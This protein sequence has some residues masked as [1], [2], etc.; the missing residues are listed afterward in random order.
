V[1]KIYQSLC[2]KFVIWIFF[3]F[4]T[5]DE[6]NVEHKTIF[7]TQKFTCTCEISYGRGCNL[8]LD[9]DEFIVSFDV[10]S[11]FTSVL[12]VFWNCVSNP[13]FFHLRTHYIGQFSGPQWDLIYFLWLQIFP[14]NTL[15]LL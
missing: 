14:W 1:L 13:P 11:L 15:R 12:C 2:K 8:D 7:K 5:E 10:V 4:L 3:Y 9:A 6:Q